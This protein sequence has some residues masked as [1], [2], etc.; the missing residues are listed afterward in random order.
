MKNKPNTPPAQAF[1][2]AAMQRVEEHS[3]DAAAAAARKQDE[4]LRMRDEERKQ[5]AFYE[6]H[7]APIMDALEGLPKTYGRY[8]MVLTD[9][10]H[11]QEK[12]PRI[13][14]SVDCHGGSARRAV[15]PDGEK[16]GPYL[17]DRLYISMKSFTSETDFTAEVVRFDRLDDNPIFYHSVMVNSVRALQEEI[18]RFVGDV[19][20]HHAA[21]LAKAWQAYSPPRPT[22]PKPL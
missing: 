9:F 7:L 15:M 22:M 5:G 16:N 4:E 2:T 10:S 12:T 18:G 3:R 6:K 14:T 8:F 20:P 1:L 17:Q 11:R 21:M 13:F 19:A